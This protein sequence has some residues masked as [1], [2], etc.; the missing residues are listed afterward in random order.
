MLI[1]YPTETNDRKVLLEQTINPQGRSKMANFFNANGAAM[2]TNQPI[3]YKVVNKTGVEVFKMIGNPNAGVTLVTAQ[4]IFKYGATI[5]GTPILVYVKGVQTNLLKISDN[6]CVYL[7]SGLQRVTGT[8]FSSMNAGELSELYSQADGSGKAKLKCNLLFPP[9]RTGKRKTA[10]QNCV[11]AEE[12]TLN[13]ATVTL[14]EKTPTTPVVN[15]LDAPNANTPTGTSSSS[16]GQIALWGG[17][18][19]GTIIAGV[20][21]YK[22]FKPKAPTV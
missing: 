20:I 11:S 8:A 1:Q 9:P 6:L 5:T 14:A 22:V 17:I 7:N 19:V 2:T 10:Y 16:M 3:R 18:I 13:G 12:A 21:L 15:P 4:N